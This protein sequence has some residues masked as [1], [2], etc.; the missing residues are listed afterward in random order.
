MAE[1][2]LHRLEEIFS[3]Q[4]FNAICEK[5]TEDFF[6]NEMDLRTAIVARPDL[7]ERAFHSIFGNTGFRILEPVY[8]ELHKEFGLDKD[9]TYLGRGDFAKFMGM[10]SVNSNTPRLASV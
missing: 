6:G 9:L 1:E 4:I 3:R 10:K 2:I 5:I 7:F 8:D